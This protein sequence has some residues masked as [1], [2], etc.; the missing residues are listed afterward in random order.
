MSAFGP[1]E[2]CGYV[3]PTLAVG[4]ERTRHGRIELGASG[5]KLA[6]HGSV[7]LCAEKRDRVISP[8]L[9]AHLL[10]RLAKKPGTARQCALLSRGNQN[11]SERSGPL[12]CKRKH[13]LHR[14]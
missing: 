8:N 10:L 4:G 13:G 9:D 5:T 6:P 14:L 1:R 12:R 7:R 2:N 3:C 11:S